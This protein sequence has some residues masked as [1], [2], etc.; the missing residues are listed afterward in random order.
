RMETVLG[1]PAAVEGWRER[2]MQALSAPP[3]P[4]GGEEIQ[5]VDKEAD[6]AATEGDKDPAGADEA[7]T[8]DGLASVEGGVAE[9]E[10]RPEGPEG[11]VTETGNGM[12]EEA[13]GAPATAEAPPATAEPAESKPGRD[14][15]S[16]R[17]DERS[18]GEMGELLG[19]SKGDARAAAFDGEFKQA[20]ICDLAARD[21]TAA[22]LVHRR[23]VFWY[24]ILS[25]I[26]AAEAASFVR[27]WGAVAARCA[28]VLEAAVGVKEKAAADDTATL[29]AL[30]D[31]PK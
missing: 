23:A 20:E 26:S 25:A 19:R 10:S 29:S 7:A 3:V 24:N 1:S 2:R 13:Q 22:L 27:L 4:T 21:L 30:L 17:W 16:L 6:V 28:D 11:G 12:S 9:P 8:Q 5:H 18:V 14:L 15:A 31:A